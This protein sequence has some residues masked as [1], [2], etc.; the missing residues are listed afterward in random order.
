[1]SKRPRIIILL[2]II[3]LINYITTRFIFFNIHGMKDFTD[4]MSLISACLT[5]IFVLSNNLIS[6]FC[7]SIGNIIGF[8]L[9]YLFN[10]TTVDFITGNTNNYWLIWLVS[11]FV[12]VLISMLV[13]KMFHV[14][15]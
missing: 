10:T 7:S 12:I 2:L 4:T 6:S 8:I 3:V 13:S 5:C 9:G 11:Y 1:M 15:H 14:K